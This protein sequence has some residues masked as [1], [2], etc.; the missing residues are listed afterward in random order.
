[1]FY[2]WRRLGEEERPRVWRLYGWFTG[3]MVTGSCIGVVTW[4]ARMMQ[5]V[6]FF[7]SRAYTN[8]VANRDVVEGWANSMK[9]NAAYFVMYA[10]EFLCLTTAKLMVLERMSDFAAPQV[11]S[12]ESFYNHFAASL[13]SCAGRRREAAVGCM[14][15]HR[16]GGRCAGQRRWARRQH[17]FRRVFSEGIRVFN[18]SIFL[19]CQQHDSHGIH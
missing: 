18:H 1:M 6:I 2:L 11:P 19:R 5:L 3:L 4:A 14:R 15:A 9:W 7:K 17:H 13:L 10:I 16:H 12:N 8:S